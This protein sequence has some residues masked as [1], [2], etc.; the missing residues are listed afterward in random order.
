MI[1]E[2]LARNVETAQR[3]VALAVERLPQE[4]TCP[5]VNALS[6]ALVTSPELVPEQVKRELAPIVGRYMPMRSG[7]GANG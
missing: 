3:V 4:R 6:N 1:L 7:K 5:C 2:N